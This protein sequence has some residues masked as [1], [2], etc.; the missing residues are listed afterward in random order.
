[1]EYKK[2]KK[3]VCSNMNP[4]GNTVENYENYEIL[5]ILQHQFFK[6]PHKISYKMLKINFILI[7]MRKIYF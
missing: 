5:G 6:I 7:K 2:C 3:C 1:M 4:T